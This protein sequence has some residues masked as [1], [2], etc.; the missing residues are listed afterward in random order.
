VRVRFLLVGVLLAGAVLGGTAAPA[1]A[2]PR[3]TETER[4]ARETVA[5]VRA[6]ER[7]G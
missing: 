3:E 7:A 5:A 6:S 1:A 4:I 2:W